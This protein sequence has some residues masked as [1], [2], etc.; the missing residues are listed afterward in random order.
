MLKNIHK[1]KL[2]L[3]KWF[4]GFHFHRYVLPW[5]TKLPVDCQAVKFDEQKSWTLL[6]LKTKSSLAPFD[7]Q[8]RIFPYVQKSKIL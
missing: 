6:V 7:L 4:S 2:N 8:L 5:F 3:H 1:A